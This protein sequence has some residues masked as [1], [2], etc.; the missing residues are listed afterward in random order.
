MISYA[1]L[2][3]DFSDGRA[4]DSGEI[5]ASF[6]A[7]THH[8]FVVLDDDPTGTQSVSDLPVLTSWGKDDF[9]W[10]FETG[11]RAVYV[12]TNSRSLSPDDAERVN[13][14]VV[15]AAFEA[16]Q[17]IEGDVKLS[18][19]SRSDSTLRGH[20][21]LEPNTIA[22]ALKVKGEET[23]GIVIVPAFGDAGRITVKGTHYAGNMDKGFVPVGQTEFAKDATFGYQSSKL[24]EWVEEKTEGQVSKDDCLMISLD[25]LRGGLEPVVDILM[26]A[27]KRQP[28]IPDIVVENDLRLFSL[29]LIEAE[30]QGK[31]FI[32]RVGPPFVRAR[33][34]QDEHPP[35]SEKELQKVI[36]RNKGATPGGLIVVGSHVG[37]TTRQ[38]EY[39][40][41]D[42][43]IPLIEMDVHKVIDDRTRLEHIEQLVSQVKERL[44][45]GNVVLATS[46]KLVTGVD[47][48]ESLDI[49]RRISDSLVGVVNQVIKGDR[50]R[51]VIAKGGITSSDVASKGLEMRHA[52]VVGPMLKGIVS[53]WSS[54]D[55]PAVG[56][57]YIIFAGNV[58][59]ETSLAVVTKKLSN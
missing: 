48:D 46:R 54:E 25:V 3:R 42:V 40:R 7:G 27:S 2:L 8:I 30:K 31:K 37:L 13:N 59:D 55:G 6:D 36:D 32:Y 51:F 34:G 22:D 16:A 18:F 12:M 52:F 1:D 4:V 5:E 58:G 49:S 29:A 26:K 38:L 10:A 9:V 19:V 53:L 47:G 14:E 50:P 41:N 17:E 44:R 24:D 35:L 33:I 43:E 28:V 11:K 21:P 15:D 57:P 45:Q 39:L 56:V 20:F 23:D